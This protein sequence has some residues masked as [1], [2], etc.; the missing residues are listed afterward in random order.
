MFKYFPHTE[1]EIKQMLD[2]IHVSKIDDLFADVDPKLVLN[3]DLNLESAKSE[4]EVRALLQK[5]AKQNQSLATFRGA[6]AYDHYTPS[7]IFPLISR[8]E[9]LTTYTPYQ[10]EIAQGT[11]RYIFEFQSMITSLTN[12]DC[13]NANMYDGAT[14]TAEA[15][16]MAVAD[17]KVKR[18]LVSAGVN[19][20]TIHVIK[21]YAQCKDVVVEIVDL[22]DGVVSL[23]DLQKKTEQPFSAFVVQNPNY[24]GNIEP[25]VGVSNL[26]HQRKGLLIMNVDPST[27]T[28]LKTPQE[29]GADIACGECQSL[30][31][32]LNFGGPYLGFLACKENLL[33]KLPGRIVGKTVDVDGK[34]GFVLTLQ[35]REQHIRRE[36]ANSNICSNQSLMSLFATIY[37]ALMGEEGIKEVQLNSYK[38]AHY[39]YEELIKTN[40]FEKVYS[41][42]FF[43]EF[44]LKANCNLKT[45]NQKLKKH[46]IEGPLILDNGHAMFAVTE[47]RTLAEMN[48]LLSCVKEA[49]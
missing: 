18:V 4:I 44:V 11:L 15:I 32:P 45:L 42:P 33:R 28:V 39:L 12:L 38:N 48:Q 31:L 21:T 8:Q 6:G 34:R 2:K 13:A 1:N 3:R 43:K 30:G 24:Y 46:G 23:E 19:P 35:A 22:N 27:L 17:K 41:G 14:A 16:A 25:L 47:K 26:V 29:Y 20:N 7:I 37:M 5:I 10:P 36:K 9:F 49:K 40:Q